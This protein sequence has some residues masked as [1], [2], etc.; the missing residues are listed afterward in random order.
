MTSLVQDMTAVSSV[1][2]VCTIHIQ[3]DPAGLMAGENTRGGNW[4][5]CRGMRVALDGCGLRSGIGEEVDTDEC[6]Q[7][8]Y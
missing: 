8:R 1:A 6:G 2:V 7:G 4:N 3:I 5:A